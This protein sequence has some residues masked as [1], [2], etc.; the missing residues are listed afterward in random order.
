[1]T[2]RLSLVGYKEGCNVGKAVI[3]VERKVGRSEGNTVGILLVGDEDD[4]KKEG[5]TVG[6]IVGLTV[7]LTVALK[8]T[9][10]AGKSVGADELDG[11]K[12]GITVGKRLGP[13]GAREGIDVVVGSTVGGGEVGETDG[14][15]VG[16]R[17]G[18]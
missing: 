7:G 3:A 18:W 5:T 16:E 4:G 6:N 2:S 11:V 9:T 10:F 12:E 1:V 13:E 17:E 15:A 14:T 8:T